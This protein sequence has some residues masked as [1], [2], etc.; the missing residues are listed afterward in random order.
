MTAVLEKISIDGIRSGSR[1]ATSRGK[2]TEPLDN[3]L[4]QLCS[5]VTVRVRP[6]TLQLGGH[7]AGFPLSLA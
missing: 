7:V 4:R 3:L 2:H 6:R 1:R 5:L